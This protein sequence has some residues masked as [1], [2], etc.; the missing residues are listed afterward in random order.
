M[1]SEQFGL[2]INKHSL[3]VKHLP[4]IKVNLSNKGS[5]YDACVRFSSWG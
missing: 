3:Y 5:V 4:Y 1:Q 2:N